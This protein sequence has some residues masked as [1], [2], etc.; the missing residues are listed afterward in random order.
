MAIATTRM[1]RYLTVSLHGS[2]NMYDVPFPLAFSP[3]EVYVVS[4]HPKVYQAFIISLSRRRCRISAQ[5][6]EC[7]RTHGL[8]IAWKISNEDK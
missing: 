8:R 4:A 2:T 5:T 3:I 1:Y 6:G 7:R